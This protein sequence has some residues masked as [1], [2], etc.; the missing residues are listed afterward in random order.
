MNHSILWTSLALEIFLTEESKKGFDKKWK[1]LKKFF[2]SYLVVQKSLSKY[3]YDT[4]AAK[5]PIK[6]YPGYASSVELKISAS[7][8][9]F[10]NSAEG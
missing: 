4:L 5:N 1:E 2:G 10:V 3:K 9:N 7:I 8:K 6:Q